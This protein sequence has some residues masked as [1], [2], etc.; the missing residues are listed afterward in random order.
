M[1]SGILFESYFSLHDPLPLGSVYTRI[2][3]LVEIHNTR[4]V[5]GRMSQVRHQE[6][7]KV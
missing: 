2:E 3:V 5:L 4:L 7:D 6:D 1:P